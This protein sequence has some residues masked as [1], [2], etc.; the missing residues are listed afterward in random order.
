MNSC[1]S[2]VQERAYLVWLTGVVGSA[3][4]RHVPP[5][6]NSLHSGMGD[7]FTV[8]LVQRFA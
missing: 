3:R 4:V 2:Y 8:R 1:T 5:C 7:E 6:G